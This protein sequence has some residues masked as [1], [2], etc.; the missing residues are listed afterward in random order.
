MKLKK[1]WVA[2]IIVIF[3]CIIG[4]IFFFVKGG[5]DSGG[6][7]L[8]AP[9]VMPAPAV[10]S[11]PSAHQEVKKWNRE[12]RL[13]ECPTPT[14]D[15]LMPKEEAIATY[16]PIWKKTFLLLNHN[17]SSDY[18]DAHVTVG[19][20][21]NI[22]GRGS[23]EV[24]EDPNTDPCLL[25][26]YAEYLEV[27]YKVKIDWAEWDNT[28]LLMMKDVGEKSYKNEAA[29]LS[30]AGN[31]VVGSYQFIPVEKLDLSRDEA[32]KNIKKIQTGLIFDNANFGTAPYNHATKDPEIQGHIFFINSS[33]GDRCFD[34]YLNLTG[35]KNSVEEFPCII[36]QGPNGG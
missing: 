11:A 7:A 28:E 9:L 18:Y 23:N 8:P 34:V 27:H 30:K 17:M 35:G 19:K 24:L 2:S 22:Y 25:R 31:Y 15:P 12:E 5:F 26:T 33:Y 29:I 16:F 10:T 1:I 4:I 14:N 3:V 36:D 32:M 20:M 13:K 21:E 6:K